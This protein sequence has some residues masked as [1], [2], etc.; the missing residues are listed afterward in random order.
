MMTSKRL[1]AN[2]APLVNPPTL[3]LTGKY[4]LQCYSLVSCTSA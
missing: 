2:V 1:S 3:L 4:D